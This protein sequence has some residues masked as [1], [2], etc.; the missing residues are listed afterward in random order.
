VL[1]AALVVTIALASDARVPYV[2]TPQGVVDRM[3]EMAKVG[4]SDYIVDLGSGDGRIVVTAA[5]KYGARGFGVDLNPDRIKEANDN[6]R[7]AGVT[8]RVSFQ[9]R[10]LFEADL[11]LATVITMYLLPRVNL[12]LRPKLLALAPGTRLV[13]HDFDMGDWKP[14]AQATMRD[15]SKFGGTGGESDIYLWIV[16][17]KAGGTW[18]W[19]AT[20]AG[21]PQSYEIRLEQKYQVITGSV[22]H[23]GRTATLRDAKLRGSDISFNFAMDVNG[24]QVRYFYNGRIEGDSIAGTTEIS[25]PRIQARIEWNASRGARSAAAHHSPTHRT[26]LN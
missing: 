9:Q 6:A 25:G 22:W 10:N 23:A 4:P 12:E 13:S 17:E 15:E 24:A 3:L 14:D 21:K 8:D 26:A 11:S 18:H 19:Q 2:P 7:R 5:K 1:P 20:V 16:P